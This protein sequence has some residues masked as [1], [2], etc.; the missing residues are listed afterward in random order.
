KESPYWVEN[1]EHLQNVRLF[2]NSYFIQTKDIDAGD[3]AFIPIGNFEKPFTGHYDG[4]GHKITIT[5]LGATD[6][7]IKLAG[8]WGFTSEAEIKN[9]NVEVN[10]SLNLDGRV[11]LG[12]IAACSNN[13]NISSCSV[14]S[15]SNIYVNSEKCLYA[16]GIIGYSAFGTVIRNCSFEGRI[17]GRSRGDIDAVCAVGGI[18]GE[19]RTGAR[20][21][22]S[23]FAETAS[24]SGNSSIAPAWVGGIAG[25]NENSTY[26]CDCH[27]V[28][29][30]NLK[31]EYGEQKQV[32]TKI[33]KCNSAGTVSGYSLERISVGGICGFNAADVANCISQSSSNTRG[34]IVKCND[35][36]SA[37][38]GGVVGD[39]NGTVYNSS[40][41]SS[42]QMLSDGFL[43]VGGIVGR[44][45]G[46]I[47]HCNYYSISGKALSSFTALRTFNVFSALESVSAR[48]GIAGIN[49]NR[50]N[51]A[52]ITDCKVF[53]TDDDQAI[54]SYGHTRG[55]YGKY[56][57]LE[58]K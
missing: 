5:D 43:G 57:G 36:P 32:F 52:S 42:I 30:M 55:G 4:E 17:D 21:K 12:G 15:D 29:P 22:K 50:S 40:S 46:V 25:F 20:I 27:A 16:G 47:N 48:G 6:G 37:L 7:D 31:P 33:S 2:P 28:V 3:K 24:V 38:I 56:V 41:I 23:T 9:L 13:T 54:S 1:A 11:C 53:G 58:T 14:S 44:N 26:V 45:A 35:V 8:L 39:N 19:N 49:D 34:S 10:A 18:V 51:T